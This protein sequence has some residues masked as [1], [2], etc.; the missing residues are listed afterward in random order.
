[1]GQLKWKQLEGDV[2]RPS[3]TFMLGS[4]QVEDRSTVTFLEGILKLMQKIDVK[5]DCLS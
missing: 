1:M 4:I 3:E 2:P 5:G